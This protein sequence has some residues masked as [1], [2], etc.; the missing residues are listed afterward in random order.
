[1]GFMRWLQKLW[2]A[3]RKPIV[4]YF[5]PLRF[6]IIPLGVLLWALLASDEGQDAVRALVE[7]ER[8]CPHWGRI[9]LFCAV[10]SA[11][12][13]QAWY[14]SRQLLR[15]NFPLCNTEEDR[16]VDAFAEGHPGIARWL[17]RILG[18]SAYLIAI[19]AL[20]KAGRTYGTRA[21]YTMTVIIITCVILAILAVLY[22]I[23]VIARRRVMA[24]RGEEQPKRV[25]SHQSL[26]PLTR[27]ILLL[28]V[29]IALLFIILT[30]V[31]PVG[32][33]IV[34]QSPSLLMVSAVLWIGLGS[35]IIYWADFYRV[36]IIGILIVLALLFSL[37]NDN[38]AVRKLEGTNVS[39]RQNIATT[40]GG[41][42]AKLQRKYPNEPRHPVFLVA[43]EGGG[44]RAAYWT[45]AVLGALQDRSPQFA[46]HVFAIS[47]VSGG[48]LGATV[49]T[50][51][52]ADRNRARAVADCAEENDPKKQTTVRFAAQ[53]MLAYDALAPGLGSLL[54]ADLVQRFLPIGFIPDRAQALEK[55]WQRGWRAHIQD[56][57][58]S[59]DDFFSS[60]F[61]KMYRD[62]ADALLP[63]LFLNTTSVEIGQRSIESDCTIDPTEILDSADTLA[64]LASDVRLSTA[65]LNSARFT[66]FSP[67]GTVHNGENRITGHVVDGGYFENSG[68]ATAADVFRTLSR[69]EVMKDRSFDVYLI[70]IKFDIIPTP[71]VPPERFANET[72]SP[73]RALL[74]TRGARGTLAYAQAEQL[75]AGRY[76]EF[77][78][79]Q[80]AQGG[81]VMPLGW[82]LARRTMSAIDEQVGN[83]VPP[84]IPPSLLP[85]V[86]K[87]VANV[88]AIAT[89]L[90]PPAAQ[91]VPPPPDYVQQ[92]AVRSE[93]EVRH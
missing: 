42:Y 67:A 32:V 2:R 29:F 8:R 41:W 52:I 3:V 55:G 93:K 15:I 14:W 47:S 35:W 92:D 33:G 62:S 85:Y 78:L 51:L 56:A 64:N 70:L 43:T 89:L 6:V 59:P 77:I 38:H 11:L 80:E 49:F 88:T 66:Y 30:A 91:A 20:I 48:S 25:E 75:L 10:V 13:L 37:F 5:I 65:A 44:I 72:L 73:V 28:T 57:N 4:G 53:Q 9:A 68:A 83:S 27:I 86:T 71:P 18:L 58:G 31:T 45:A 34:F 21:G 60:G 54:H 39:G 23:F 61:V 16:E 90:A 17:P 26:A 87:N 82:L 63:Y 19:G 7:F 81:I 12:A 24:K 74:A 79:T 22:V 1:M 76:Y 36:P 84:D 69:P 50:G 46:D 40:F